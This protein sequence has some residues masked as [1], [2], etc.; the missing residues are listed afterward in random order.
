MVYVESRYTPE[1]AVLRTLSR[2]PV[3]VV[4][5]IVIA[6]PPLAAQIAPPS[7]PRLVEGQ[8]I[9]VRT[10]DGQ[11]VEGLVV[12]IAPNPW[13]IELTDHGIINGTSVDS[14]WDRHG[15]AGIGAVVGVILIG[16]PWG[17]ISF[18]R[19]SAPGGG[20]F[21]SCG[22][23][24]LSTV[25]GGAA[26]AGVGALVGLLFTSWRLTYARGQSTTRIGLS[27]SP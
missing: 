26:S 25:I 13:A 1:V 8:S 15:S 20:T 11:R 7:L 19:C 5:L 3:A 22:D 21:G 23:A 16:V 6:F 17:A 27:Y 9:R 10:H 4:A 14:L 24:A 12:T 18:T 2:F